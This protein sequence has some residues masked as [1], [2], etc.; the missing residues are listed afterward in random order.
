MLD[1][2]RAW[3]PRLESKSLAQN[4]VQVKTRCPTDEKRAS[5][6]VVGWPSRFD[7]LGA[8]LRCEGNP[9]PCGCTLLISRFST[10]FGE[11]VFK[12]EGAEAGFAAKLSEFFVVVGL[13]KHRM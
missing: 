12:D 5:D 3:A 2:I 1:K 6:C 7:V 10:L 4:A 13:C 8:R 9:P 11:F